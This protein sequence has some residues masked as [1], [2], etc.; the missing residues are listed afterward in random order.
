MIKQSIKIVK[1]A[2]AKMPDFSAKNHIMLL[3]IIKQK[4][5]I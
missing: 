4:Y 3:N 1:S 2:R 5:I